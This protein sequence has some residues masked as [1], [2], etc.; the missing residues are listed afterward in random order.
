MFADG[1]DKY[2]P[3]VE[4][5][6]KNAESMPLWVIPNNPIS[7]HELQMAMRDHYEGTP[8]ALDNDMGG[9]IWDMPY[10]PTPLSYKVDGKS[11]FNERPVSTQQSAFVWVSQMRSWLPRQIGGV[12]W[13]ANDDANMVPFTPVYCCNTVQP[14]PYNT[15]GADDLTFSMDNAFWVCNWV[16]NM[17]YPRYNV[18]FP[19]LE[20]VRDS[21]ERSYKGA[22]LPL[23]QQAMAYYKKYG[24]KKVIEFLNEYS[25][26]KADEMLARWKQLATYLIVKYNDMAVKPEKDGK[27]LKTEYGYGA[28]VKR[29]GFPEKYA[30]KIVKETG[31]K[32]AV[33]E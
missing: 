22:Q 23:E 9:G 16:S 2:I 13:F 28:T 6:V 21:L 17:V 1:M 33:P 30:R 7:L 29:P 5:K 27:F 12:L 15:P 8:F 10:R 31:N 19:S 20:I 25:C 4:G 32:F 14:K 18:M 11:Y 3:Y 24:E 26:R